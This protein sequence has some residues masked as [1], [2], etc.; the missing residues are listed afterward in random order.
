MYTQDNAISL[1][2]ATEHVESLA[3]GVCTGEKG[4]NNAGKRKVYPFKLEKKGKR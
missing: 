4:S 1:P 2:V 3:G